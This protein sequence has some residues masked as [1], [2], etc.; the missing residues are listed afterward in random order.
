MPYQDSIRA[1]FDAHRAAMLEDIAALC[2]IQSDRAEPLPDMPYG[3]GP[4][5]ALLAGQALCEREGFAT[6]LNKAR[7]PVKWAV[8]TLAL[9]LVVLF[10]SLTDSAPM[11]FDF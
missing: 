11:Y 7:G 6:R 1:W 8:C 10:G 5:R 2:R 3:E 9:A 4:F